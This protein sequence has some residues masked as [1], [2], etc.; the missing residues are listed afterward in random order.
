MAAT[1]QAEQNEER[2]PT[3]HPF[4]SSTIRGAASAGEPASDI[5][6]LLVKDDKDIA[7]LLGFSL[8]E[9]SR[10]EWRSKFVS[11]RSRE[12][13]GDETRAFLIGEETERRIATYR[14][15]AEDA[16]AQNG[17]APRATAIVPK[18][19]LIPLPPASNDSEVF[20]A[21]P[22]VSLADGAKATLKLPP[23]TNLKTLFRYLCILAALVVMLAVAVNYAKSTLFTP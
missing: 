2:D 19:S 14:T 18:E 3:A 5:F 1:Q 16:L 21:L 23:E 22:P 8:H 10:R 15:M 20:T 11:E 4:S 12:P 13:D 6:D 9:L 17:H 7:G